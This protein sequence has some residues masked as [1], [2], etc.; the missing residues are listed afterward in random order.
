MKATVVVTPHLPDVVDPA[1]QTEMYVS[2]GR[3]A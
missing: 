3:T 1:N 2:R